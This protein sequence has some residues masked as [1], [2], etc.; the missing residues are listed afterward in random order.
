MTNLTRITGKIRALGR[1]HGMRFVTL[2]DSQFALS[3]KIFV[4]AD[5]RLPG[6]G[7]EVT[8]RCSHST[9]LKG[10]R[11]EAIINHPR[12]RRFPALRLVK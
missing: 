7:D 11:A 1:E 12:S 5:I 4:P 9:I 2:I 3:L 6:L 10:W 8:L